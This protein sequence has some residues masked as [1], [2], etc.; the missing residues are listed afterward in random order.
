MA[1]GKGPTGDQFVR[2]GEI[3]V[4]LGRLQAAEADHRPF[5]PAGQ[6]EPPRFRK[7]TGLYA[8]FIRL[9]CREANMYGSNEKQT[10]SKRHGT[11]PIANHQHLSDAP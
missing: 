6:T 9:P 2:R 3:E 8:S 7:V 5:E 1:S 10:R 4:R 11:Y